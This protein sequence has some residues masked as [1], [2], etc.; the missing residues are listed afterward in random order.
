MAY[1]KTER[2]LIQAPFPQDVI[3]AIG[4]YMDA[5]IAEAEAK[6]FE[7]PQLNDFYDSATRWFM[8]EQRKNPELIYLL[9]KSKHKPGSKPKYRSMWI[10]SVLMK[11][12]TKR[13]EKD[14]VSVNRIVYSA[15][16]HWLTIEKYL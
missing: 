9:S 3:D 8:K 7:K 4:K 1:D 14:F 12:L 2:T 11:D 5:E 6:G 10:D 15:I 16:V 13:A